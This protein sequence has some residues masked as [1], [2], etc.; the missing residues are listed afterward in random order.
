MAQTI[1]F[2]ITDDAKAAELLDYFVYRFGW[3]PMVPNPEYDKQLPEDPDTNPREI[4][5][6]DTKLEFFRRKTIEFWRNEANN[7]EQRMTYE[8]RKQ[9]YINTEIQ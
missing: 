8:S 2:T 6:P 7:G 1:S 5:H 9:K 3:K 4:P